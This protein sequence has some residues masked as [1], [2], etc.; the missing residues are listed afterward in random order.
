MLVS[1][2]PY[3]TNYKQNPNFKALN[4][5]KLATNMGEV[6]LFVLKA[7]GK[8]CPKTPENEKDLLAAIDKAKDILIKDYLEEIAELWG[9][10]KK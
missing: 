1:F 4:V 3:S 6:R 8:G 7:K 9:I 10:L 5:E 2:N